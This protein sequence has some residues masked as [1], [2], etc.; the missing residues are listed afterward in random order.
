MKSGR[1]LCLRRGPA[2]FRAGEVRQKKVEVGD[3]SCVSCGFAMKLQIKDCIPWAHRCMC[4][5]SNTAST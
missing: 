2:L 4:R 5:Q 3:F 1:K